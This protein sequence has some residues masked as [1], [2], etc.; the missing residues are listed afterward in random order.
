MTQIVANII[1]FLFHH[2]NI[3][4]LIIILSFWGN[5]FAESDVWGDWNYIK[6]IR[7]NLDKD[8]PLT[9]LMVVAA[10]IDICHYG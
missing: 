8:Q 7:H 6:W 10:N 4:L 3:T 2:C 1:E 5:A 9:Q